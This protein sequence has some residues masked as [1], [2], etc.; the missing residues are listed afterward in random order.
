MPFLSSFTVAVRVQGIETYYTRFREA[1]LE[2][3]FHI[4][5]QNTQKHKIITNIRE[6]AGAMD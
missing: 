5:Q 6:A 4:K 2:A 3:K 1:I